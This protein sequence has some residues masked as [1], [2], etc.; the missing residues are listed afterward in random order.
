VETIHFTMRIDTPG[1]TVS[2]DVNDYGALVDESGDVA[3]DET[4]EIELSIAFRR[5]EPDQARAI[6]AALTRA[7]DWVDRA[8]S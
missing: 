8:R 2:V 7:A 1:H 4:L 5:L 6:A 3:F